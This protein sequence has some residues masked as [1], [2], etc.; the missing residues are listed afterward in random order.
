GC[1]RSKEVYF[2]GRTPFMSQTTTSMLPPTQASWSPPGLQLSTAVPV[3]ARKDPTALPAA[4]SQNRIVT[5]SPPQNSSFP[6][7]RQA[8]AP[9]CRRGMAAR[10]RSVPVET[11]QSSIP[12][13][14]PRASDLPSGLHSARCTLPMA[15]ESER[16]TFPVE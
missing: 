1:P 13:I 15:E 16:S 9:D 6:S 4:V 3:G 12:C 11:S 7:G 8:S 10:Q 14:P 2:G 5:P